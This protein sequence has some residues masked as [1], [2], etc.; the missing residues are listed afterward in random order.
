MERVKYTDVITRA[1]IRMRA[2]VSD[3]KFCVERVKRAAN[4]GINP[5]NGGRAAIERNTRLRPVKEV[6]ELEGLNKNGGVLEDD[7]KCKINISAV[8]CIM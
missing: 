5:I 7:K 6:G 4:L 3:G 8:I 1:E 2:I